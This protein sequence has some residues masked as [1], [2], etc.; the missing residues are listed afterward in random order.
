MYLIFCLMKF[1]VECRQNHVWGP[2][3][4]PSYDHMT[5]ADLVSVKIALFSSSQRK[6][7]IMLV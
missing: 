5:F 3:F 4:G 6:N 1:H 2:I 7:H